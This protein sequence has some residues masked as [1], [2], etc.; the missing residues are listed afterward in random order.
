VPADLCQGTYIVE[1]EDTAHNKAETEFG[2]STSLT[3]TVGATAAS[4][5]HV[6]EEVTVSGRGFRATWQITIT[7]TSTPVT[8]LTQSLAD[9]SFSYA[10]EVPPS[11]GGMHVIT[12]TDGEN[13]DTTS[14]FVETTPPSEVYPLLPLADG[15]LEGWRFDWGGDANDPSIEV[16][17]DSLP[18]TYELQVATN[19]QFTADAI[20]VNKIELTT[21]EYT[22]TDNEMDELAGEEALYWRVRAK[23][24]ASNATP[25]TS[26][27]TFTIGFAFHFPTWLIYLLI[28]IGAI[29]LFFL[30]YWLGKRSTSEE[31]YY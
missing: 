11:E 6:G 17:D 5:G 20:L 1:A 22:L 9:G 30:G 3:L 26:A 21:S 13:T 31:Y 12:A 27:S 28:A 2:I 29:G 4:P 7:Y 24:A 15:E 25:W 18:I 19:G 8:F 10:F 14:F 23:D 16:T